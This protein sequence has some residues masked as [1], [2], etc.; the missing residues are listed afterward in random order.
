MKTIAK[1]VS[2]YALAFLLGST[3]SGG[4]VFAASNMVQAQKGSAVIQFNGTTTSTPPKLVYG[5]TT[6]LPIYYLQAGLEKALGTKPTWN[7]HTFNVITNAPSQPTNSNQG[8]V[9]SNVTTQTDALGFTE[10]M[11]TAKNTTSSTHSFTVVVTFYDSNGK[12]L[13]TANGAVN[14]LAAGESKTFQA[15][16]TSDFTNVAKYTVQVDTMVQ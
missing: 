3:I 15:M 4:V 12:I 7:G 2:G 16:A 1:R 8:I 14:G 6:Y 10:V 13:G 11:G 9:F 5:G